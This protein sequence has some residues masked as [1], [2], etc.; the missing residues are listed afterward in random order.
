[1]RQVLPIYSSDQDL[2]FSGIRGGL[3]G[4]GMKTVAV[5]MIKVGQKNLYMVVKVSS[6]V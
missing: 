2:N 5:G 1:M 6:Y 4:E 3:A